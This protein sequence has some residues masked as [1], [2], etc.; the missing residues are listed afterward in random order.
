MP[1][2]ATAT[3]RVI[4]FVAMVASSG[5]PGLDSLVP[6]VT[7]ETNRR[8]KLARVGKAACGLAKTAKPQ[9]A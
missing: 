5:R 8:R 6:P 9:A 7:R 4:R 2:A 1:S 3:V